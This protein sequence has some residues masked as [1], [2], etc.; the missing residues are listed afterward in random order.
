MAA[1]CLVSA[2]LAW[3]WSEQPR[4]LQSP[5]L[6]LATVSAGSK[7]PNGAC[8]LCAREFIIVLATGRSGSTS[9][10]ETL[11]SL[12]GVQLRGTHFAN[13]ARLQTSQPH[14]ASC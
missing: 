14:L 12:P 7:T 4:T 1:F 5:A 10:L 3:S 9:L 2:A 8:D 13:P 6:D 11:N